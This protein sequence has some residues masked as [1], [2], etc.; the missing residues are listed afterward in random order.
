M[1]LATAIDGRGVRGGA[2]VILTLLA[3]AA[4]GCPQNQPTP[5]QPGVT[6]VSISNIAFEPATVT[7]QQG[8]SVRWTNRDLVPHT[9]SSGNP[10]DAVAGGVFDSGNLLQG[11]SFTHQFDQAGEFVYFCRV[12]PLMMRDAKVI[13][14][15]P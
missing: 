5:P 15:A 4:A 9:A 3:M 7:I 13:V 1:T 11:E 10:E 14:T 8:Q 12:H 2:C 6:D